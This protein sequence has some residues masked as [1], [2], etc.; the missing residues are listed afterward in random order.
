MSIKNRKAYFNYEILEKKEAGIKLLG[1]EVKSLKEGQGNIS[2]SYVKFIKDDPWLV[3]ANIPPYSKAGT[4]H[5][6]DPLRS[7]KLLLNKKE[8][9]NL[10]NKI[11]KRGFTIVP[12][13]LYVKNSLI[14]LEIGLGKGKKKKTKKED[15][16]K[17]QH[18][19]DTKRLVKILKKS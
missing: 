14:K 13:K 5:D 3:N 12:L 15:L 1:I 6:Y 10:K 8:I 9:A 18:E 17:K 16:I 7:R 19:R 2:T 4:V 11:D